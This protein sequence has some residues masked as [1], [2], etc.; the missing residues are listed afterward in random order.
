MFNT[1]FSGTG[2][3]VGVEDRGRLCISS[4]WVCTGYFTEYNL[5][6]HR[7]PRGAFYVCG[8]LLRE[9]DRDSVLKEKQCLKSIK[10]RTSTK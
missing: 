9:A 6:W 3:C 7:Q 1:V 8:M 2:R 10:E 4:N 5:I